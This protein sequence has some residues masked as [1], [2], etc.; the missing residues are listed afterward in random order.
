MKK[1]RIFLF[2]VLLI[3]NGF[4]LAQDKKVNYPL[5][6][7]ELKQHEIDLLNILT[8]DTVN[9]LNIQLN[10]KLFSFGL[11][12]NEFRNIALIKK[13]K[14]IWIQPLGLGHLYQI[15]K[16]YNTYLLHRLDSTVHSGVN[17][18]SFTFLLNDTIFQYG[19]TGFWNIRGI[20]TY[21]SPET[22]EWELYPSNTI[23]KAYDDYEKIIKIKIDNEAS[24][25]YITKSV[26]FKNIPRDFSM[27]IADSCYEFDFKTKTWSNL[28]AI[29]PTLIKELDASNYSHFILGDLLIFQN[30]LDYYWIDF[31]KNLYGKI[32]TN[33]NQ[34]MK[35][36]W[37]SLY[38]PKEEYESFQFNL[39]NTIYLV[40]LSSD[41]KL[42]YNT[43][44]L[45]IND[46]DR[47][48]TNYVYKVENPLVYF[49]YNNVIPYFTPNVSITLLVAFGIFFIVYRQRKKRVPKEVTARLNYNFYNALSVIEK[50]LLQVLYRNHQKGEVVSIKIINKIIGVQNKDVLT[51]NKSRS[52]HF[53]KI[54]QKYKIAT[55]QPLP[56]IVKS[57][58]TIDK[59]QYNYGLEPSYL[60]YLEKM[61][62]SE[63]NLFEE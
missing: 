30:N 28:G 47:S 39:G 8:K 11:N 19:G 27:S 1:L 3:H 35:E 46:I 26:D 13:A 18:E 16:N 25:I 5:K 52:D 40:K 34:A 38:K 2:I 12:T 55:Q 53:L 23:V 29:N 60:I 41:F 6:Q 17:F 49:F 31:K 50:E 63:K 59:R 58:D 9:S 4:S 51:Q 20:I 57:R 15:E 43:Y 56:L 37:L 62:A 48:A 10:S 44:T 36:A 45:S 42:T 54:N 22:H 21:F 7:Q 33:K 61:I 32:S 24:K 14:Q